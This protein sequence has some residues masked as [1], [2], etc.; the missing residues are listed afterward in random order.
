MLTLKST[1]N[2]ASQKLTNHKE[3]HITK[4]TLTLKLLTVQ[5]GGTLS[6]NHILS[7]PAI[8][9]VNLIQIHHV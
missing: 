8:P 6:Q 2:E 4:P 9:F 7:E 5:M 1:P 3:Q